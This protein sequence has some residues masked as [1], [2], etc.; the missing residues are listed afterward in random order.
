[1]GLA[2]VTVALRS[3]SAALPPFEAD[4]FTYPA[5]QSYGPATE[6]TWLRAD[7]GESK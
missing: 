3:P 5:R 7:G 6:T 2:P 4:P 1:M